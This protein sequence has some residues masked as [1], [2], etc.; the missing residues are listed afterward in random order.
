LNLKSGSS[1]VLKCYLPWYV[2]YAA[3]AKGKPGECYVLGGITTHENLQIVKID[4]RNEKVSVVGALRKARHFSASLNV[5]DNNAAFIAPHC[6]FASLGTNSDESRNI[7]E[8]H[9]ST[10]ELINLPKEAR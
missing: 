6:L 2:Q 1:K 4:Y 5:S 3:A 9:E 7:L 10:A 8:H